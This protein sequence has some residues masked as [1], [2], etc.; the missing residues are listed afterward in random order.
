MPFFSLIA[1]DVVMLCDSAV[2]RCVAD[3]RTFVSMSSVGRQA[4]PNAALSGSS[5]QS[6]IEGEVRHRRRH[7]Y[8]FVLR[9][10]FVC[11]ALNEC[12][13]LQVP[14]KSF[15]C[16]L[17]NKSGTVFACSTAYRCVVCCGRASSLGV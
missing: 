1:Y 13:L 2:R 9:L 12:S 5:K 8:R 17:G 7:R 6:L 15:Q 3:G 14:L 4:A 16:S 11:R 10:C